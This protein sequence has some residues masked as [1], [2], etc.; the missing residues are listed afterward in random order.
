MLPVSEGFHYL[1][2]SG[3][4]IEGVK[5]WG[6]PVQPEFFGWAFNRR[7]GDAIQKHWDLIP[8]DIQVL[9]THGPAYG[10]VDEC[11]NYKMPWVNEKVGCSN[12]LQTIQKLPNLKA[13][14]CGHIHAAYGY[15]YSPEDV[16]HINA[17]ICNEQYVPINK[18]IAFDLTEHI[19][20]VYT[21]V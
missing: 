6:S 19:A 1:N 3:A 15:A 18:P 21:Y 5:F 16:L 17:S 20:Q 12:L 9:V 11:P 7:R 4:T 13:H 14:V 2:D 8:K 10:F